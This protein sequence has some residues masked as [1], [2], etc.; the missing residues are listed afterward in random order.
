[1]I[2]DCESVRHGCSNVEG[3]ELTLRSS[4]FSTS[5]TAVWI[6]IKMLEENQILPKEDSTPFKARFG[7]FYKNEQIRPLLQSAVESFIDLQKARAT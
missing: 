2:Y 3:C 1:M 6:S 4:P 5:A 7:I